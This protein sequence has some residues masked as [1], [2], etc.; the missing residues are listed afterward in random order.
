MNKNNKFVLRNIY[1]KKVLVPTRANEVGDDPIL[2]NDVAAAIWE[3]ADNAENVS[4]LVNNIASKYDVQEGSVE[5]QA[6]VDFVN[7]LIDL[8][9]IFE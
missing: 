2:M 6:V 4:V 1:D 3:E 7:N 5:K 9:L 8:K